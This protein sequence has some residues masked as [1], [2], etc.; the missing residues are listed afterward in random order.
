MIFVLFIEG[1]KVE[2]PKLLKTYPWLQKT[3]VK[4]LFCCLC[5]KKIHS[6]EV[7]KVNLGG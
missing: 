3:E 7:E 4:K 6:V 5:N 2:G 1:V